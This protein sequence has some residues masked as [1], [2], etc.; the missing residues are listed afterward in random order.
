MILVARF[1]L[2]RKFGTFGAGRKS[3]LERFAVERLSGPGNVREAYR[4]SVSESPIISLHWISPLHRRHGTQQPKRLSASD[5]NKLRTK[6]FST[7]SSNPCQDSRKICSYELRMRRRDD[8]RGDDTRGDDT[9]GDDTQGDDT[10]G[11]TEK[12]Q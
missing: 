4:E 2:D 5:Q 3:K 1:K 12:T 11:A 6:E 7:Q 10:R 9:R 8:T